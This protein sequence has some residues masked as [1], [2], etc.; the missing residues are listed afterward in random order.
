MLNVSV[1]RSWEFSAGLRS[2]PPMYFQSGAPFHLMKVL[3]SLRTAYWAVVLP[4]LTVCLLSLIVDVAMARICGVFSL[5]S[6]TPL[7]LLASSY[8]VLIYLT[9]PFSNAL[10]TIVF[11]LFLILVSKTVK[12]IQCS[13]AK[14]SKEVETWQND[15]YRRITLEEFRNKHSKC[16]ESEHI[17]DS[18]TLTVLLIGVVTAIGLFVRPTFAAFSFGPIVWLIT[19][20]VIGGRSVVSYVFIMSVGALIPSILI[21]LID[22]RYYHGT[23]VLDFLSK[24]RQCVVT[25]EN[26]AECWEDFF[27]M[28]VVTP[29]NFMK[30]NSDPDNLSSHGRHPLYTHF[31]VNLPVLFGPLVLLF[32][33]ELFVFLLR[34]SMSL[35]GLLLCFVLTPILILSMFSHQEPRFLLPVLPLVILLCALCLQDVRYK[36]TCVSLWC[37]FN[38]STILFYGFVHQGG[39][40]PLLSYVEKH[41]HGPDTVFSHQDHFFFYH[42]YM[43]PRSLLLSNSSLKQIIDLQGSPMQN[44]TDS[45]KRQQLGS[46]YVALPGTLMEDFVQQNIS[47]DV[48][49]IFPLHLSVEDP[50]PLEVVRELWQSFKSAS[51]KLPDMLSLYLVKLKN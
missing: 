23:S 27:G 15:Q 48:T 20:V 30:Y 16:A 28:F 1:V 44:L 21:V 12:G 45:I 42:T 38:L 7:R 31:L 24:F 18:S 8:V 26:V 25:S 9:R 41:S 6:A 29:W 10:E 51:T 3:P 50:P 19:A 33:R 17:E 11:S 14:I 37:I 49:K 13:Q 47:F 5:E 2:V 32:L 43:P 39:V 34:R 46:S 22:T 4:R 40:V 35:R 36:Q